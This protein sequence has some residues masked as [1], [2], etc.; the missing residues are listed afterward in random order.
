MSRVCRRL[1]VQGVVQ[2]VGFRPFVYRTAVAAGLGGFVR[3]LGDAGVEIVVEGALE[4]I[5]RFT[6]ALKGDAPPLAEIAELLVETCAATGQT[7]FEIAPSSG[8]RESHGAIP[9]DTAICA[10]CI[11]DVLGPSRYQ[12]YWATSCTDCGPRF[13]VIEGLPYDRPLTSMADFPMCTDC[14]LEYTD[15]LDR[16]Y[17]AQ[18]IACAACGPR[19]TFDGTE[20]SA[21]ERAVEAVGAFAEED[22]QAVMTRFNRRDEAGC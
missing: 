11:S 12:G 7:E 22:I 1:H 20:D 2:G 21:I 15:P 19:L 13:T 5:E 17:H 14:K 9:P 3:N 18:T 10:S 6:D 4:D 8:G 16:R